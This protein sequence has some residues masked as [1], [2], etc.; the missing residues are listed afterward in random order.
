[1]KEFRFIF[2]GLREGDL[3]DLVM[4]LISID[5]FESKI[6]DG[7]VVVGFFVTD[8]EPCRDLNR[9][10]QKSSVALLDTDISPAP[11]SEGYFMVF[12]ELPRDKQFPSRLVTLLHSL[13]DLVKINKW[14]FKAHKMKGVKD[15]T[16]DNL[17]KFIR[18]EKQKTKEEIKKEK[19]VK[20]FF[21]NSF[22]DSLLVEG[23]FI[24]LQS[25]SWKRSYELVDF[26]PMTTLYE[27]HSLYGQPLSFDPK[28][29]FLT[30][31][32]H[33]NL[34]VAWLVYP[35]G[36]SIVIQNPKT[37]KAMLIKP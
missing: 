19:E 8:I 31:E 23:K 29:T 33:R 6:D 5:E 10:I 15:V 4:P 36:E 2:E 22:L 25:G 37:A 12:V 7:A 14:T 9:F 35:L 26:G 34:G 21:T 17:T 18:L 11:N 20:E 13:K 28:H 16:E 3:E 32:L 24:T 27:S 30:S 1:M